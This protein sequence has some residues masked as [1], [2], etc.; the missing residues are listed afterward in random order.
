M[1]YIIY[2]IFYYYYIIETDDG[3][4]VLYELCTDTCSN[5][6]LYPSLVHYHGS[7][8]SFPI[9]ISSRSAESEITC[10]RHDVASKGIRLQSIIIVC[11]K[12]NPEVS[13]KRSRTRL[14]RFCWLHTF[15]R[16]VT[17][18]TIQS[19]YIMFNYRNIRR[20]RHVRPLRGILYY[21]RRRV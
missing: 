7:T 1:Y 2:M 17:V 13:R 3:A 14:T 8:G 10:E 18:Y 21:V 9:P 5:Q 4:R 11:T 16:T 15:L 6:G 12:R 19:K 20:L